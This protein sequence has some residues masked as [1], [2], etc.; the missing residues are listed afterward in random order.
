MFIRSFVRSRTLGEES[1]D[2]GPFPSVVD[3][4]SFT[5][6]SKGHRGKTGTHSL[7]GERGG[8]QAGALVELL[9]YFERTGGDQYSSGTSVGALNG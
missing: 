6:I 1:V 4:R 8:F 2:Q 7:G 9:S 5:A 3:R